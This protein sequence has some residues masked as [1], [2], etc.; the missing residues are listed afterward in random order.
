MARI[1]DD[2]EPTMRL[3]TKRRLPLAPPAGRAWQAGAFAAP[4]AG[5]PVVVALVDRRHARFFVREAGCAKAAGVLRAAPP[6]AAA[7]APGCAACARRF[8]RLVAARLAVLA[9]AN[10]AIVVE[11]ATDVVPTV[12]DAL[13]PRLRARLSPRGAP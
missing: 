1:H 6:G 5:R 9:A 3:A 8:G 7:P 10:G 11:G 12:H 4:D 13:P 2:R